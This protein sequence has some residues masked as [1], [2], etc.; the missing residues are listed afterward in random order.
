MTL[1]IHRIIPSTEQLNELEAKVAHILGWQAGPVEVREV[2]KE[3]RLGRPPIHRYRSK[4]IDE[5][6]QV[7]SP[8]Q[9]ITINRPAL[10][11]SRVSALG[12]N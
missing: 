2:I 8:P 1:S 11:S 6:R 3:F 7:I 5:L 9:G 10:P 4:T 12:G